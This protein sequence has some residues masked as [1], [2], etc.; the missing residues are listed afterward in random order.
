[1][2]AYDGASRSIS[3]QIWLDRLEAEVGAEAAGQLGGD[4]PVGPGGARRRDLLAE[5]ADPALE[6]GGGAVDLGEAGGRQHDVGLADRLGEEHVDGDDRAGAGQAPLGEVAVGE[7]GQR[8]GAEQHQRVDRPSAAACEDAGGVEA[9]LGRARV[10]QALGEPVAAVVERDPAGQEPG[11]QAHVEGAV[12]VGPAQGGQER[13]RP[14]GRRQDGRRRRRRSIGPTRPARP[15]RATTVTGPSREQLAR[16]AT[17]RGVDAAGGVVGVAGEQRPHEPARLARAG[18]AATRRR[19]VGRGRWRAGPARRP[20]TPSLDDRVA[21]PQEEDRQLLL[22]VGAEQQDGAA[23]RAGLVDG[24]PGQAEH[25]LGRQAVAE[26]GV[27]VVGAETPLASL[28]QA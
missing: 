21:Q 17:A 10:G 26:L 12:D 5:P 1:M 9:R 7:V 15:G 23:G 13:G 2:P 11:R 14:G 4:H 16:P 19:S 22:E 27:D 28:A 20:C 25:D 6:V 3:S 24:G 18:S 8:V